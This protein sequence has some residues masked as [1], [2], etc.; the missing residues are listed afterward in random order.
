VLEATDG[1]DALRFIE[2]GAGVDLVLT[3]VRMPGSDGIRL[4]KRIK[5]LRP[6]AKIL[7]MTGYASQLPQGEDSPQH[8]EGVLLKPFS[9]AHLAREV[10]RALIS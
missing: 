4:A 10:N 7:I 2:D 5:G 3:D 6:D 1:A 9:M 8:V